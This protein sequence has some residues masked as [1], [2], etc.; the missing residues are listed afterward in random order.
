MVLIVVV[1][2]GG[3]RVR[4]VKEPNL[5]KAPRLPYLGNS[6]P[7]KNVTPPQA[8]FTNSDLFSLSYSQI[9]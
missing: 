6:Y 7:C 8:K 3:K 2:E 9:S 4:E 5:H 1:P